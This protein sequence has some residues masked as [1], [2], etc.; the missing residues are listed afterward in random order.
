MT[1]ISYLLHDILTSNQ[2]STKNTKL[3]P[4]R[5]ER[6]LNG[7]FN[8]YCCLIPVVSVGLS[9]S[10]ALLWSGQDGISSLFSWPQPLL[11]GLFLL[12]EAELRQRTA[13]PI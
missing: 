12:S 11:A 7:S 4:V 2:D 1:L 5:K 8:G 3:I 6:F 13:R 10:R 9:L